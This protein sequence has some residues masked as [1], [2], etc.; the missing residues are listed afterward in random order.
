V[1]ESVIVYG[2]S[3]GFIFL[4]IGLSAADDIKASRKKVKE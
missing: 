4:I 3:F 2:C 1:L